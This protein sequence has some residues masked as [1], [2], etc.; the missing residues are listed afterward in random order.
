MGCSQDPQTP[1]LAESVRR[2]S[3]VFAESAAMMAD[4]IGAKLDKITFDVTF[5][6]ATGDTDLS[7]MQIP[8]CTVA[9]VYGYHRGWVGDR[10]V[11]SVGFN[12]TMG[13]HVTP[14]K[15]LE[16]G[17]VIQVFG[18]PNMSLRWT[19]CRQRFISDSPRTATATC[20]PSI[21][22]ARIVR[23]CARKRVGSQY[24]D[25]DTSASNGKTRPD[26]QRMLADIRDG[27][28]DAVVAWDLDRLYR[29]PRELEDL[30]DLADQKHL[31]LATVGGEADL[32]TDNGRLFARIKGAVA[33]SETDRKS[34]RQKRAAQQRAEAGTPGRSTVP[35]GYRQAGDALELEPAEAMMVR[36]AYSAILAGVSL[37]AI[38][39]QWNTGNVPTRRG[40][41]WSGATVRQVL[42]AWR[43]AGV[44]VYK[45]EPVGEGAWPA[46]VDRD[47][48]D[49]VRAV[50]TQPGR[51][52]GGTSSGRKHL[53][54]GIAVCGK[55]SHTM[56]SAK[57]TDGRAVYV[58]KHCF[59]VTRDMERVDE[60]VAGVV[61]ARLARP[62]ARELLITEKR[63]DI[64]ALRDAAA[65]LR[66]RQDEAAVLFADGAITGS[67][68]KISTASLADQLAE[69]ESKMLDANKSRVFD[70]V[71]GAADPG[72]VWAGLP[73]DRRRALID[74]LMTVTIAPIG[75]VGRGFDPASVEIVWRTESASVSRDP[76]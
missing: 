11:V 4:A 33:K 5:T 18:L 70:G 76:R 55:C 10:N 69:V 61:V 56:G 63:T 49:G 3:E 37:H 72:A 20:S 44:A 67:Q 9:G 59:G 17:H 22:S 28:I 43:N 29:Q 16:H 47:V 60:L 57:S 8:K 13:D 51:R 64:N 48:F 25:N 30:I 71:I 36:D 74:I 38:T 15:P 75:R 42:M 12:W 50:L 58:C 1:G 45:G 19:P 23:S 54:S 21:D 27:R 40:N 6:P 68:L 24:M 2:E 26:Y 65:A 34:A 39:R 73:L 62:D 35:F 41:R 46:I 7:F 52:I 14:P 32:S 66:A 53:L 31:A